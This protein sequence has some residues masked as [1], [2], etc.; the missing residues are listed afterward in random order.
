MVMA[1][2]FRAKG[3]FYAL[4]PQSVLAFLDIAC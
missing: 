4:A 3:P 1:E 2:V